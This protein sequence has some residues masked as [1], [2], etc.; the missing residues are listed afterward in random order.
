MATDSPKG[1]FIRWQ[2]I[3]IA[4][5]AYAVNL[6]LGLSVA[7]LAFQVSIL[8]SEK[9]NPVSWQNAHFHFRS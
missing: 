3:S 6:F 4:Q 5:L 2:S 8:L 9:F 7:A 1:S